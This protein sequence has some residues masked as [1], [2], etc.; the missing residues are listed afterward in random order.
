VNEQCDD[1]NSEPGDGCSERCAIEDG[2]LCELPGEACVRPRCGDGKV[3]GAE[4]CDDGDTGGGDGCSEACK[5]EPGW[6]CKEAGRPCEAMP[7]AWVC[8]LF[9]YGSG[10]GCDCGC[11]ARDPDCPEPASVS[12]CAFNHCLEDAPYPSTDDPT[13]CGSEPPPVE[14]APVEVVEPGPEGAE[15]LG[16]AGAEEV[17][18]SAPESVERESPRAASDGC[19]GGGPAVPLAGLF[20]LVALARRRPRQLDVSSGS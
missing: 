20:S 8:S 1:G 14:E 5:R 11:G 17:A 7:T 13:R 4:T 6:V 19:A 18:E 3:E 9:L 16:D 10:D 15:E 2:W 12:D